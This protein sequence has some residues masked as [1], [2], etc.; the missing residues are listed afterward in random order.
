MDNN[1][2]NNAFTAMGAAIVA[3]LGKTSTNATEADNALALEGKTASQ[4]SAEQA[5]TLNAHIANNN[6]PH[7]VTADL[8][9]AYTKS[10]VDQSLSKIYSYLNAPIS[11]FGG[12]QT[13]TYSM[14]PMYSSTNRTIT[15]PPVEVVLNNI[16]K[17]FN[18]SVPVPVVAG[19]NYIYARVVSG[20]IVLVS[21]LASTETPPTPESYTNMLIGVV[22]INEAGSL[23]RNNHF[24]RRRI[25]LASVPPFMPVDKRFRVISAGLSDVRWQSLHVGLY[26][27]D[28][29]ILQ[30]SR[31]LNVVTFAGS[32]IHQ[33]K[34]FDTCGDVNESARFLSHINSLAANTPVLVYVHDEASNSLTQDAYTAFNKIGCRTTDIQGKLFYRSGMVIL[35]KVGAAQGTSRIAIRGATDNSPD[36]ALSYVFDVDPDIG[37][38]NITDVTF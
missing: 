17:R 29:K 24:K 38:T 9:G 23:L 12:G 37:F 31:G 20:D 16:Y 13:E 36:S 11:F 26:W 6:N 22:V 8:V 4:F 10:Q 34:I 18:N 2:L 33:A 1:S 27:R 30:A 21:E 25:G 35:G 5:A 28:E 7:N 15:Y 32:K 3:K 19:I 14:N